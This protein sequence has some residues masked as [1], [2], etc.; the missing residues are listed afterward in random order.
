MLVLVSTC[1]LLLNAPAHLC[2]IAAK[3]YLR[4]D[5]PIFNEHV[6]LDR[7]QQQ[8]NLTNHQIKHFVFIH[9]ENDSKLRR[10]SDEMDVLDEN[11]SIHLFYIAIQITQW[12]SYLSY[13]INFFLYSVS[14]I[15]FRSNIRQ[16]WKNF[17]H[18]S[19][20]TV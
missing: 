17:R 3:I 11:I 14:G 20:K 16:F 2:I 6:E 13:S 10:T 12:I 7:F 1:F 4:M 19:P 8:I 18:F 5:A 15:H 9:T